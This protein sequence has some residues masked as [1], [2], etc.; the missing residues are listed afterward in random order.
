MNKQK[1]KTRIEYREGIVRHRSQ[2]GLWWANL[3]R[4]SSFW[5]KLCA[6]MF[7]THFI[8]IC[9]ADIKLPLHTCIR[10][11]WI[12][13]FIFFYSCIFPLCSYLLFQLSCVWFGQIFFV[14]NFFGC[15]V[16]NFYFDLLRMCI[17]SMRICQWMLSVLIQC[18]IETIAKEMTTWPMD[19]QTPEL[20]KYF[21]SAGK[22]RIHI[23]FHVR[24]KPFIL[25]AG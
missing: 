13:T 16:E 5:R 2:L 7:E 17:V 8:T 11:E 3:P 12:L 9:N 15:F 19:N 6:F 23:A 22:F 4:I 18:Q 21:Y 1:S 25:E 10:I 20:T 14:F 24:T